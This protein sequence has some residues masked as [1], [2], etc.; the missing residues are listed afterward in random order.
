MSIQ[1]GDLTAAEN[2]TTGEGAVRRAGFGPPHEV[3]P[4]IRT[5]TYGLT[6]VKLARQSYWI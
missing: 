3:G 6:R 5:A 4:L 1:F 2:K